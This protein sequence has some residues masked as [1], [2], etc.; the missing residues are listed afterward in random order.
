[1]H[2]SCMRIHIFNKESM[3]LA[4]EMFITKQCLSV[5]VPQRLSFINVSICVITW[6]I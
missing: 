5:L 4:S 1:M 2:A 6:R 3:Q